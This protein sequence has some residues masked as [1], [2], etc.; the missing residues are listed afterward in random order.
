MHAGKIVDINAPPALSAA[1]LLIKL[2]LPD[3]EGAQYVE[4]K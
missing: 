2:K 1:E 4:K 3:I